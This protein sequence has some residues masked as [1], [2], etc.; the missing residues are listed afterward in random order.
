MNETIKKLFN[1]VAAFLVAVAGIHSAHAQQ[2][3]GAVTTAPPAPRL[4]TPFT[5]FSFGDVY[6]GEVISHIFIIRNE[7][8]ADLLVKDFVAGCGCSVANADKVIPPGKEGKAELEVN[9]A[10]QAGEIYKTATLHTND[11]EK[12]NIVLVLTANVLT[13]GDGG[14]VKGVTL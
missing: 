4:V 10:T 2:A 7:G 9:T 6:R 5:S 14:P 8:S 11:P 3:T 13:S 1:L 12:P